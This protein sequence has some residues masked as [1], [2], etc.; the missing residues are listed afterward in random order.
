MIV[1]FNIYQ[2][3]TT[4]V[5]SEPVNRES[6]G[7]FLLNFTE[8]KLERLQRT[9]IPSYADLS[10]RTVSVSVMEL[11]SDTFLPVAFNDSLVNIGLDLRET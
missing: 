11:T 4:H 7:Q 3:E 6:L 9:Q 2:M 10:Y 5:M 1:L 8:G